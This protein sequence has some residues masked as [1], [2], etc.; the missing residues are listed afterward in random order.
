MFKSGWRLSMN[1]L[2]VHRLGAWRANDQRMRLFPASGTL[3]DDTVSLSNAFFLKCRGCFVVRPD[4]RNVNA[5]RRLA[6]G[7]PILSPM[8]SDSTRR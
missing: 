7:G 5:E 8:A 3:K 4:G 1:C 2:R 6:E